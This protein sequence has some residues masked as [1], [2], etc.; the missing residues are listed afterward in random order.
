MA[1]LAETNA[2]ESFHLRLLLPPALDEHADGPKMPV[3]TEEYIKENNIALLK[4]DLGESS[5]A[6]NQ[7]RVYDFV[8]HEINR[9]N[10]NYVVS[11]KF[12][13]DDSYQDYLTNL[14]YVQE[15]FYKIYNERALRMFGK[16]YSEIHSAT[17]PENKQ[18]YQAIREGVPMAISLAEN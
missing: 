17:D 11:A 5:G 12:S 4:V 14:H 8:M 16:S 13:E 3:L 9:G 18:A 6:A 7:T 15:G 1:F 10:S 2:G